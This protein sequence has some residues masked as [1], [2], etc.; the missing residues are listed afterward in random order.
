M[1]RQSLSRQ[2]PSP[3]IINSQAWCHQRPG[4]VPSTV[5]T[6]HRGVCPSRG[7]NNRGH[8][9][10]WHVSTVNDTTPRLDWAEGAYK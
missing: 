5:E 8:T 1:F 10:R 7:D 6:S 4:E 3:G 2:N 9:R